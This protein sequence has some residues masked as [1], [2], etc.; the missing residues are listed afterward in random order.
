MSERYGRI[1]SIAYHLPETRLTNEDIARDFPEWSIARI[2]AKTGIDCRHLT[3]DTEF[4]SDLAAEACRKLFVDS[5]LQPGEVDY[6]LLCTQSPDY[7]LPTTACL[8]QERLGLPTRCGAVDYNLGCSGYVYGLGLAEGLIRSG[9]ARH[10]LLVTAETYSKYLQRADKSVRTIFGD[11]ASATWIEATESDRP[12]LGPFEY[13]TDGR[14]G[15]NLIV[16]GSGARGFVQHRNGQPLE[17][18]DHLYMNGPEIF[19]FTLD[20]V[21]G[22]VERT[23][24]RAGLTAEQIDCFVLHQA[25]RYMLEHLREKMGIPAEKYPVH[26][27]QCGNTVSSTIP[28]ALREAAAAGTLKPGHRALLVGFGVGY[29]WAGA[30]MRWAPGAHPPASPG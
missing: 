19:N 23:L 2:S 16:K 8:V 1:R 7:L 10:V 15:P 5:G 9:Q 22:T 26:M 11:A 24:A 13:G 3:T 18:A 27:A 17:A 14:G 4:A 30:V 6:L 20:Q 21:P 12:F 28:I 25:N 29:S